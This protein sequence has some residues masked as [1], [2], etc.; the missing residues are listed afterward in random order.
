M[1]KVMVRPWVWFRISTRAR[2]RV[3]CLNLGFIRI[4]VSV[5]IRVRFS[6]KCMVKFSF[7]VMGRVRVR[8]LDMVR[9]S[10]MARVMLGLG[11][12]FRF[13]P[14]LIMVRV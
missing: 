6:V 8:V 13:L 3:Q 9:V 14:L 10:I 11:L 12:A 7:S 5:S 1:V 2:C 4:M